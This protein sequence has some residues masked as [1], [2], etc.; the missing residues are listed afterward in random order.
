MH[1]RKASTERFAL[2][3]ARRERSIAGLRRKMVDAAM[4]GGQSGFAVQIRM[5]GRFSDTAAGTIGLREAR[6]K[7]R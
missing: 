4:A 1:K 6:P 7:E 2:M 3:N 5:G